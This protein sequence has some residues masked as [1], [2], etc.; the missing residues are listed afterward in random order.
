MRNWLRMKNIFN[1]WI[2]RAVHVL[3][4]QYIKDFQGSRATW[5]DYFPLAQKLFCSAEL[6]HETTAALTWPP[7]NQQK[8]YGHVSEDQLCHSCIKS[9]LLL[10]LLGTG[11]HLGAMIRHEESINSI[12]RTSNMR[13]EDSEPLRN[14]LND[15]WALQSRQTSNPREL[16]SKIAL[17]SQKMNEVDFG[18]GLSF[19]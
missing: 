11:L 10:I 2:A 4:A 3:V 16:G 14:I 7:S 19:D 15:I 8:E 6:K 9:L 5:I 17:L 1:V 13:V 18:L 12:Q